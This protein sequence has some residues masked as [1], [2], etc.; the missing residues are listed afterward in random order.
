MINDVSPSTMR[1]IFFPR[2]VGRGAAVPRKFP[3]PLFS[4]SFPSQEKL[5]ENNTRILTSNKFDLDLDSKSNNPDIDENLSM[6]IS[7]FLQVS[8]KIVPDRSRVYK[9]ATLNHLLSLSLSLS[10]KLRHLQRGGA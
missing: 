9:K 3:F 6:T 5:H 8:K 1:K 7:L 2:I 4:L 10:L